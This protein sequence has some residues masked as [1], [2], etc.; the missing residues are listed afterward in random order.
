MAKLTQEEREA[1]LRRIQVIRKQLS[2]LENE[3][4]L[5][6][7]ELLADSKIGETESAGTLS[8]EFV[9]VL[10]WR[11][12]DT[13]AAAVT[14]PMEDFAQIYEPTYK[15]TKKLIEQVG[16]GMSIDQFCESAPRLYIHS[17]RPERVTNLRTRRRK[18]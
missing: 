15:A 12:F 6:K 2:K 10:N 16:S 5:L 1:K 18:R 3:K 17:T 7:N 13:E 11:T 4:E 14:F 8:Y 9:P